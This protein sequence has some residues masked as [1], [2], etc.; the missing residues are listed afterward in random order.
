MIDLKK[1]IKAILMDVDGVLTDGKIIYDSMGNE[2]KQFNVQD[3]LGIS[4]ALKSDIKIFFVTSRTSPIVK[5]RAEELRITGF[6][7]GVDNKADI[8]KEISV[9][10][11]V[12]S[13]EMVFVGD[14][15][16]DIPAMEVVGFPVAV[17]NAR[18][19]VKKKASFITY[20]SGGNGAVREIIEL[21]LKNQNKWERCCNLY[22]NSRTK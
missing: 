21:I 2:I 20:S 11:Q 17:G 22:I 7:Q 3:G 9:D 10:Y 4:L 12:K 1:H 6:F 15:L 18:E 19:E 8:V 5:R 13:D 14:D 16:V